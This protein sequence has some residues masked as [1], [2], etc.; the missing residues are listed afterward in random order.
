MALRVMLHCAK[1]AISL[2]SA[3]HFSHTQSSWE[4]SVKCQ[5]FLLALH[6]LYF[7]CVFNLGVPLRGILIPQWYELGFLMCI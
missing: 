2:M 7:L 6:G 4:D 5:G 1:N 3:A